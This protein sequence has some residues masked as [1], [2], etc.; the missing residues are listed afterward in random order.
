MIYK[1]LYNQV[2]N[3]VSVTL[4]IIS[5]Y[6]LQGDPVFTLKNQVEAF[7]GAKKTHMCFIGFKYLVHKLAEGV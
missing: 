2:S 1:L 7:V 4:D 5:V 3:M 6:R